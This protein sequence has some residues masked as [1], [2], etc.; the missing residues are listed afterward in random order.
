MVNSGIKRKI[1]EFHRRNLVKRGELL[2]SEVLGGD[3]LSQPKMSSQFIGSAVI[4]FF[5][6]L[7]LLT[8]TM[9][10]F[11]FEESQL[12]SRDGM[13]TKAEFLINQ[14]WPME[15][16]SI[17][18]LHWESRLK[19]Y[20]KKH[21]LE[22]GYIVGI[23]RPGAHR[24]IAVT[25]SNSSSSAAVAED[26]GFISHI[27]G[28]FKDPTWNTGKPQNCLLHLSWPNRNLMI[29]RIQP[30]YQE[31]H[32]VA[33]VIVAYPLKLFLN[34]TFRS[35]FY[36]L[37][38]FFF[39][40]ILI[41]FF[42]LGRWIFNMRKNIEHLYLS[43][44]TTA[45]TLVQEPTP[46]IYEEFWQVVQWNRAVAG[47]LQES[48]QLQATLFQNSPCGIMILN[49]D[50][51]V[52]ESNSAAWEMLSR[53]DH[54]GKHWKITEVAPEFT[55]VLERIRQGKNHTGEV[56][57]LNEQ[58]E[59]SVIF[60]AAPIQTESWQGAVMFWLDQTEV[61]HLGLRLRQTERYQ[62]VGELASMAAHELRN[63]L[64]TIVANAQLGQIIAEQ[65]KAK[66][67][68]LRIQQAS[69]RM[70]DFLSE[71][72]NMCRPVEA[73]LMP[74]E[75]RSVLGDTL[76]MVKAQL[77]TQGI[78]LDCR[79]DENLP[80]IWAEGK[81]LRQVFLNLIQNAIQAMPAGGRLTVKANIASNEVIISFQ[82]T[83]QGIPTEI[84]GQLFKRFVTSKENGNGLGL[85]IT[86]QI[87]VQ[88]FDGRIWFSSHPG[89]GTEFFLAFPITNSTIQLLEEN[90][91]AYWRPR[92]SMVQYS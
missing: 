24:F 11:L 66:E 76:S 28:Y 70:S 61:K 49:T 74:L 32:W 3:P 23:A 38:S 64:T 16:S 14:I 46:G 92:Q 22:S 13:K 44:E 88:T 35:L 87:M 34:G 47:Q 48:V 81:L 75:V 12:F 89:E 52:V 4:Y 84:Q 78:E 15:G 72:M 56:T 80:R 36:K 62:L 90:D 67:L 29:A 60:S 10:L 18:N 21:P 40:L 86:Q 58:D 65:N 55:A 30:V 7:I 83:G 6:L 69:H 19:S 41:T 33:N 31:E 85:F 1:Q 71:M 43:F 5:L 45:A 51:E 63:P 25:S 57:F 53:L 54:S 77:L 9:M 91:E 26:A 50:G 20:I 37:L 8:S 39:L 27:Q 59:I 2:R 68:F 79:I 82:D 73:E 17:K 42:M